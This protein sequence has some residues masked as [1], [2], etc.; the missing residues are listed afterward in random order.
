MPTPMQF[1][2][3]RQSR[4][5]ATVNL[6]AGNSIL[7]YAFDIPSGRRFLIHAGVKISVFPAS[8]T[9]R[10]DTADPT[11]MAA[12]GTSIHT[13]GKRLLKFHIGRQPFHSLLGAD[14]LRAHALMVDIAGKRLWDTHR[15]SI[16]PLPTTSMQPA[17]LQLS[18]AMTPSRFLAVLVEFPRL[19]QPNFSAARSKHEVC[20]FILT[21]GPPVPA[22]ARC[23]L[24]DKL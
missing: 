8:S 2:G 24:A 16:T 12:N 1:F 23:L 21:N 4:P 14:F 5:S 13:F 11:L 9:D 10:I 3:K 17:Y 18:A 7:L 6:V 19:T 20:H 15:L 22:K